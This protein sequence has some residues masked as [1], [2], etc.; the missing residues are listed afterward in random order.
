MDENVFVSRAGIKLQ[1]AIE[2]F[3]LDL[4]GRV[5]ADFGCSTGGFT[6]CLLKNGADK[7][8]SVDTAYGELDYGL[9]KNS[10]V[11]VLERHNAM[12]VQLPE[13]VD[14]ITIDV[15]WTKQ[16]KVI[17]NA[18][19]NLKSHG[20]ILTL[21]KPHYE[22]KR[23]ELSRGIAKPEGIPG[24]LKRTEELFERQGLKIANKTK[25]PITG[26]RAGNEE[27]VY[28]LNINVKK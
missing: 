9:R 14:L 18:I 28:L 3:Q 7:V 22:A 10:K 15:A 25:S 21:V 1:H 5:C 12:H 2:E 26:K 20:I 19:S 23:E 6:D 16:E 13:K 27:W 24:I 17:P 8:Y 11:V 4:S